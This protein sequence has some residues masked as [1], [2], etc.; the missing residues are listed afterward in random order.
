MPKIAVVHVWIARIEA[1]RLLELR[2]R[3]RRSAIEHQ[4]QA[5]PERGG[6][7]V[8]IHRDRSLRR[9]KYLGAATLHSQQKDPDEHHRHRIRAQQLRS[10]DEIVRTAKLFR[11]RRVFGG[12]NAVQQGLGEAGQC[13]GGMGVEFD[14]TLQELHSLKLLSRGGRRL[15]SER[16]CSTRSVTSGLIGRSRA[17]RM[18]SLSTTRAFRTC[19]MGRTIS[20][21]V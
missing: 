20:S 5:Q 4:A 11:G 21:T 2:Y 19:E 8:G 12:T 13:R 15:F 3:L 6:R 18:L 10:P 17:A 14:G 16:A 1:D 7:N 9:R